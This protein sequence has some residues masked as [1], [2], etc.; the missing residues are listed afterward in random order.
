MPLDLSQ[1]SPENLILTINVHRIFVLCL[2]CAE[3]VCCSL[4]FWEEH[5]L[6]NDSPDGTKGMCQGKKSSKEK[7]TFSS[8]SYA[9]LLLRAAVSA[10]MFSQGVGSS[11]QSKRN[12]IIQH[13][14][15]DITSMRA[16]GHKGPPGKSVHQRDIIH[17][18]IHTRSVCTCPLLQAVWQQDT[19][20]GTLMQK[21]TFV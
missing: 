2:I 18:I 15:F 6:K 7:P 21:W 3:F 17:H 11:S 12:F 8:T 19:P 10:W 4:H 9:N 5:I 13:I 16:G 14:C 20:K 1:S